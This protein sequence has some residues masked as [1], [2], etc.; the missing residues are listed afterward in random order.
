MRL[1][2]MSDAGYRTSISVLRRP[3]GGIRW[4]LIPTIHMGHPDYYWAIWQ[5]LRSC[6]AVVA[7]QYDGPS[8]TGLAYVTAMRWTRQRAGRDLVHQDIDYG[9]LGVPVVFP[10]AHLGPEVQPDRRMP[11]E[12][13]PDL[14]VMTPILAVRM[15]LAGS[16][17]VD[18]L[19]ALDL[20]DESR[21]RFA[22][23]D[24]NRII[25]TERDGLLL[26]VIR[27]IDGEFAAEDMEVA[28]VFGA[29]HIPAVV[30]ELRRLGHQALPET[31]WLTAIDFEEPPYLRRPSLD[32]WMDW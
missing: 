14:I 25:L 9:A 10:D 7:E 21:P 32:E 17:F 29:L 22:D 19:S 5:R 2:E 1:T 6:Q 27:E 13:W 3:G 26:G 31:R 16:D 8:S 18:G 23:E 15:A 4:V 12:A 28:V 11:R 30:R 24:L 20:T